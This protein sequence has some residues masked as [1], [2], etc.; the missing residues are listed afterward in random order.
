MKHIILTIILALAALTLYAREVT[1]NPVTKMAL[2]ENLGVYSITGPAGTL[3]LGNEEQ[4]HNFFNQVAKVFTIDAGNRLLDIENSKYSL[5]K[6][7]QGYY[8]V[9]VGMGGVKLRYSDVYLFA[10]HFDIKLGLETG[11]EVVKEGKGKLQEIWKVVTK[12]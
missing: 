1:K 9:K 4:S 6:D 5:K 12:Q 2:T 7:D 3:V 10:A 11:K 8:L